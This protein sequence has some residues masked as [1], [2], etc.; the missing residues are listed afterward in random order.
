MEKPFEQVRL[1]AYTARGRLGNV[2]VDGDNLEQS[3][4]DLQR[5]T[6]GLAEIVERSLEI[7]E[8]EWKKI[9][10]RSSDN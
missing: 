2:R 10:G 9:E 6:L 7:L 5:A 3:L 1:E 8:A 4:Y